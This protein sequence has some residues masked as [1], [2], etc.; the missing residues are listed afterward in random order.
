MASDN[1]PY[2]TLWQALSVASV[3][4]FE[5]LQFSVHRELGARKLTVEMAKEG[6]ISMPLHHHVDVVYGSLLHSPNA[7]VGRE[8]PALQVL[9]EF[10]TNISAMTGE[11]GDPIAA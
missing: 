4:G 6:L 2:H 7:L 10:I 8:R 3:K 11:T 9:H 5:A 1:R